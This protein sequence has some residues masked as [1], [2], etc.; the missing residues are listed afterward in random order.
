MSFTNLLTS[1]DEEVR[2]STVAT[3]AKNVKVVWSKEMERKLID[4]LLEQIQLGRKGEGGFKKEAWMAIQRKFNEEMKMN[5]GKDNFKNK[6]K[7][8]KQGYRM[9]K[10][11]RN[12]SGFAWNESTQCVDADD[13]VWEELLKVMFSKLYLYLSKVYLNLSK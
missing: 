8:W 9:M 1:M 2:V 7:T 13:S 6:Y 5:L 12:M 11:L 3:S 10:E 4:L